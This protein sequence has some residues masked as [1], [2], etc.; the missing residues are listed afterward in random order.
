MKTITDQIVVA[1][2][3]ITC[4]FAGCG[5]SFAV[6]A[7]WEAERRRLHDDFY[8]PNGHSLKFTGTTD[9]QRRIEKLEAEKRRLQLVADRV[10]DDYRIEREARKST[11]RKLSAT[12]GVLTRTKNRVAR[13]VC[14]C[15]NRTFANLARHMAGQHPEYAEGDS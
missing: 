13:G 6:P 15:C 10:L 4:A 12:K 14:P 3:T 1:A 5:I 2:K 7:W 11:Q 8:C 9:E